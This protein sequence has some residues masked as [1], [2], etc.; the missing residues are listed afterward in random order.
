MNSINL[1]GRISCDLELKTTTSGKSVCSF[2]LAVKRPHVK[3]TTDFINCVSW[4][5]SAEY[6]CKYGNKGDTVEVTGTLQ[7]RNYEDKNGN[8]RTAF[9]VIVDS[10]SL[11]VWR[12]NQQTNISPTQEQNSNLG[13]FTSQLEASGIEFEEIVGNGDLPF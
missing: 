2:S 10:L 4:N 1:T 3:N 13:A 11:V 9:E 12:S 6:L 5:Q 8:K 7:S